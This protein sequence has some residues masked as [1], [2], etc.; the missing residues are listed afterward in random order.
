MAKEHQPGELIKQRYQI[1]NILGKG[2]VGITYSAVD[3]KK[4]VTVAIKAVS[5]RQLNDWK[6][7]ELFE[8]E[9]QVLAKLNHPNIP[10]YLDYF[11]IETDKDKVFYIVQQLAPGK[12]LFQL[13]E[14]GWRTTETEVKEIAKQILSILIYL[15]SLTPPVIHRDIKPQNLIRSDEGKIFLVDFG[16]VQNTYY[17]TL[18]Q[19]STVVGTYGYMAPEQFRGKA[20]PTTDLY[21]LGATLLYLLTHRPPSELP[22]NTL[23]IDFKSHVNISDNFTSW[24]DKILEPDPEDRFNSAQEALST[25]NQKKSIPAK[26]SKNKLLFGLLFTITSIG[27]ATLNIYK[28]DF[29]IKS[30]RYQARLCDNTSLIKKYIQKTKKINLEILIDNE[31]QPLL[32]CLI[33]RA[34]KQL[35]EILQENKSKIKAQ[36]IYNG[37]LLFYYVKNSEVSGV[38]RL[39]NKHI[40]VNVSYRTRYLYEKVFYTEEYKYYDRFFCPS[41]TPLYEAIVRENLAIVKLLV[42]NGAKINEECKIFDS[43]DKLENI[44]TPLSKAIYVNNLE[45]IEFLI[46]RDARADYRFIPVTLSK[47]IEGKNYE[48]LKLLLNNGLDPTTKTSF[49]RYERTYQQKDRLIFGLIKIG[50]ETIVKSNHF[51][52]H[53]LLHYAELKQDQEALKLF[54]EYIE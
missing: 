33:G 23:K 14:Q 16:A 4:Q 20:F 8:R 31:N 39:L 54:S 5:L 11:D 51:T 48:L 22:A 21:S 41:S 43:Q 7:V 28:Y 52:Y 18:M 47:V 38:E 9:A 17:D 10:K 1:N 34:D 32:T 12:S 6:Q 3:T 42:A 26:S 2:G 13:V 40:N 44:I 37:I 30:K 29:L 19:G 49:R 50:E 24:L 46:A 25:L 53:S 36:D 45:I 27:L 15:H 35:L